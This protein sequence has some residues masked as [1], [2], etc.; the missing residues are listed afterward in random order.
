MNSQLSPQRTFRSS[1]SIQSFARSC[2]RSSKMSPPLT[3]GWVFN[4][5]T[6]PEKSN[7]T[8]LVS[9]ATVFSGLSC[10]ALALRLY[11]RWVMLKTKGADDAATAL[12]FVV[13]TA[14]CANAILRMFL[15]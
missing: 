8:K 6:V 10:I 4:L 12:S 13:G 1:L 14:Y 7:A 9:I 5:Q 15:Q 11:C 2:C 3:T